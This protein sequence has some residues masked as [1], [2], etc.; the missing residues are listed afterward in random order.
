MYS[1]PAVGRG[2]IDRRSCGQRFSDALSTELRRLATPAGIEPATIGSMYSKP[3][4]GPKDG[5]RN[6]GSDATFPRCSPNRQLAVRDAGGSRTHCYRVA[7]GCLAVQRQRQVSSS[8]V[9]PDPRPSQGRM[10]SA[11]LRGQKE[12]TAGF[13]PAW[14]G[15]RD[16]CLS[17]SSHIGNCQQERTDLNCVERLWRP[18]AL[19]GARSCTGC[20]RG[21]EPTAAT[22]TGPHAD[23][24]TTDTIHQ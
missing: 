16:R 4:V 11:T 3:A 24:Y 22:F 7:A 12:P 23:H 10:H 8:G 1:A 5:Q 19:P 20:P 13:A 18:L 9:E 21:I 2:S 15:L 14:G 17:T 6:N